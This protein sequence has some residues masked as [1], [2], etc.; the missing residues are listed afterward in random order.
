MPHIIVCMRVIIDPEAPIS[1]FKL[2]RENRKQIPPVGMPPVFN[3]YDMNAL[4]AALRLKD[5]QAC[6]IT[7]LS[8]GK[9]VPKTMLQK[10]LAMGADEAVILEDLKFDNLDP[11]TMAQILV[12]AIRKVG[13]YELIFIGRQTAEWD[14]G[15]SWAAMAH[16]L[17]IPCVTIAQ[18]VRLDNG[19]VIVERC[20]SDGIETLKCDLPALITF[21]SEVGEPRSAS[22]PALMKVKKKEISKWNAGDLEIQ[23]SY[24]QE[25]CDLYE[26]DFGKIQCQL[27]NEGSA[28][29]KGRRLAKII[30]EQMSE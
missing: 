5:H 6:K 16:L 3:P 28:E 1:I 19:E 10:A 26:P 15:V 24:F 18:S 7:V 9:N 22:I 12:K 8:L 11:M 27:L 21:S 30:I 4:E 20:V 29:D 14:A 2:D 25:W 23:E 17:D 13:D